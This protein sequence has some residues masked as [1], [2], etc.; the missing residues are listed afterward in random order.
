MAFFEE[1][2]R[3]ADFRRVNDISAKAYG[4]RWLAGARKEPVFA[5][6]RNNQIVA[7]CVE[8]MKS[9]PGKRL[10]VV[11][12]AGHKA[13][14]RRT[15]PPPPRGSPSRLG[16][17]RPGADGGGSRSGTHARGSGRDPRA[18]PRR[19]AL[20]LRCTPDRPGPHGGRPCRVPEGGRR[21]VD[22][23]VLR[24]ANRDVPRRERDRA[25]GRAG[26]SGGVSRAALSVPP[27]PLADGVRPGAGG[28]SRARARAA[29]RA[30]YES[31][32][33]GGPRGARRRDARAPGD[34]R[35]TLAA[36]LPGKGL[37]PLPARAHRRHG[38]GPG[39]SGGAAGIPPTGNVPS[40]GTRR[41][42]PSS[43]GSRSRRAP[44]SRT[45]VFVR[46]SGP[47]RSCSPRAFARRV[48][49]R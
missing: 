45:S 26:G 39:P 10:V 9:H 11:I 47:G 37:S 18:Q 28:A 32:G 2:A 44:A 7:R 12:G 14:P 34:L 17:G 23:P 20:V 19:R 24:R 16:G 31:A 33:R 1:V 36:G 42:R 41:R 4:E 35:P 21:R 8:V 30:R 13:D 46:T 29:V 48:S 43:C 22:R 6:H 40:R 27:R 38:S 3:E 49:T 25:M 5:G 15:L